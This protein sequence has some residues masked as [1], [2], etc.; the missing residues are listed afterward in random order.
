[1]FECLILGDS[2][3]QGVHNQLPQC[4]VYARSGINSAVFNRQYP[5]EFYSGLVVI[6]LGSNDYASID[7][8]LELRVLRRRILARERVY[9]VLPAG[10]AAKSGVK[11]ERLRN[12][13]RAIAAE[14]G[15]TVLPISQTAD[16]VH[17]TGSAYLQLSKSIK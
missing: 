1:M 16:G 13:V 9:W 17:P 15:D 5:G 14:Y 3:A 7:S 10:T 2:I 8:E 6:S 4:A 12:A 11:A